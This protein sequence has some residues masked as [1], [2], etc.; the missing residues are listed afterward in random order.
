MIRQNLL[1][2]IGLPFALVPAVL[3]GA[4]AYSGSNITGSFTLTTTVNVMHLATADASSAASTTMLH[5]LG[6]S[7]MQIL[8]TE[9]ITHIT[10]NH[11]L[12]NRQLFGARLGPM[13]GATVPGAVATRSLSIVNSGGTSFNGLTQLEQRDANHGNQFSIEPPNPSVAVANGYILEGV[14]N[15]IQ[16]YNTSGK[17]LLPVAL[18]TNELFGL[19][20]GIDR[21]TFIYGPFPTDMRVFFDADIQRW[22]VLQRAQDEDMF[23]NNLATSHVYLA[24]SQTADPTGN[25]NIYTAD[26]TDLPNPLCPC[27][28]DYPQ[29]GADRYGFFISAN[30]Y[31]S[32]SEDFEDATIMALSKQDLASGAKKPTVF[33]FTL[34][35]KTGY[36]F[37]IQP[38]TTPPGASPFLASG[39]VEY[40]ASSLALGEGG[41]GVAVWAVSNTSS[42][43][44]TSPKLTLTQ[45]TMPTLSYRLPNT[46]AQP[47]GPL[48][49]NT[50]VPQ[51]DGGDNRI[52][53][54]TY[55]GA[56]LYMTLST[57][58]LDDGGDN[59][60]GGI[61]LV[62]D[63]LIRGGSFSVIPRSQ[64][65][66]YVNGNE[67]LRPSVAVNPSGSGDV[68]ATL[69]GP[70]WFP[71][72]AYIPVSAFG[73]PTTLYVSAP[74]TAPEDGYSTDTYG[75]ARWG[76]YST[77][78][79]GADGS[80]WMA[81]EYIGNLPRSQ[82][83]NWD[84]A[85]THAKQ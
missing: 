60:T 54:L 19:A 9:D 35:F 25:Y 50:R 14:N 41:E 11:R 23:G 64:N 58:V 8:A 65:Y 78:V 4:T 75:Y 73:T 6:A 72:A 40:L 74:G 7:R 79:A 70:Q 68:S 80:V 36:E 56:R 48:E 43:T 20:P 5:Q 76:D 26:T 37:A 71:S 44:T 57:S 39:G 84:T 27:V 42:L 21:N 45:V 13:L 66:F 53:S 31:N 38:A 62:A 51:I 16:I 24:V 49:Y 85:I 3:F 34:N 63:P 33:R 22:I 59:V 28:D 29:I 10:F 18:S 52:L 81:V 47:A 82:V 1:L 30:Q 2:S 17:S 32:D 46:A 61:L 55:A 12:P 77:A 69:V 83:A 15:A 67:L